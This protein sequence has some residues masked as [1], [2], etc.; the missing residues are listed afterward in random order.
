MPAGD[1][2]HEMNFMT[3]PDM[4]EDNMATGPH[5]YIA[6]STLQHLYMWFVGRQQLD[7]TEYSCIVDPILSHGF[8]LEPTMLGLVR[9]LGRPPCTN[10]QG[11]SCK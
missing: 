4:R 5:R 11:H 6:S 1:L 9:V 10:Q 3:Y 7:L 2:S 8:M